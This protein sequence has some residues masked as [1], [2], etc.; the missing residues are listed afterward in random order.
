VSGWRKEETTRSAELLP[1]LGY[2]F[3]IIANPLT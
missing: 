3:I 1:N 2:G